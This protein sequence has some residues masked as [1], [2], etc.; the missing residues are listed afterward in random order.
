VRLHPGITMHKIPVEGGIGH[1][2]TLGV[3]AM[4]LLALPEA[5]WFLA[6]TLPIGVVIGIILRLTRRD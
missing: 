5:R 6:L 2:F 1:V 4:I 3:L